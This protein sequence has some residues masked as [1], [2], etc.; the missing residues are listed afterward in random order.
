MNTNSR[1]AGEELEEICSVRV[2]DGLYG[3]PIAHII[4]ILGGM[5]PKPVPLAPSFVGGLVHYRGDVL[6]SVSLRELLGLGPRE[7]TQALLVVEG[8]GGPFGL[9]VDTVG[10]IV[11]VSASDY[12]ANPR[13]VQENRRVLF[14]GAYKLQQSLLIM[15]DPAQL[16]PARLALV[17]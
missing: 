2:G 1:Q 12:E 6:T 14:A 15:L 3:L 9:L 11:R 4:E 17:D 5:R 13:I 8:S 16:E 7:E 10:N